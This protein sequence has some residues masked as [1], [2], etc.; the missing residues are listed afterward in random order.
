MKKLIPLLDRV[1]VQ[2]AEA[3][4]KTA[5][6]IVIPE[7]AQEKVQ[8]GTVV[9]VGPGQRNQVNFVV[10]RYRNLVLTLRSYRR[11]ARTFQSTSKSEIK[12]FSRRSAAQRSSSRTRRNTCSSEKQTSLPKLNECHV[13]LRER[14]LLA[15]QLAFSKRKNKSEQTFEL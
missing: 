15:H 4:T 6:G 9:A 8:R 1:L 12:C 3:L 5:G 14:A 7:K 2:R 11:M 13:A 10:F